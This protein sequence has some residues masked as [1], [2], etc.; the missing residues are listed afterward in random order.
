MGSAAGSLLKIGAHLVGGPLGD[1]FGGG[2]LKGRNVTLE[3]GTPALAFVARPVTV[4][5]QAQAPGLVVVS[6]PALGGAPQPQPAP[7]T[8]GRTRIITLRSGERTRRTGT[9][10][11][12]ARS[13]GGPTS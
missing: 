13:P 8:A 5:P 12:P 3:P 9:A 2:G 4:Q 10:P 7:G 1:L 6:N 11:P